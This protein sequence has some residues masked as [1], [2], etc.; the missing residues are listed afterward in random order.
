M[1]GVGLQA[2]VADEVLAR[3]GALR[4]TDG[5]LLW[6]LQVVARL[7]RCGALVHGEGGFVWAGGTWPADFA[8]PAHMQAAIQEQ[9]ENAAQ[10]HAVLACAACGCNGLQFPVSVLAA[11]LG[12]TCLELLIVLDEI[13]RSLGM[14]HDVR[15]RDDLYAFHSSFLLEVIRGKLGI[16]GP[17]RAPGKCSPDCSRVPRVP[18]HRPG[19]GPRGFPRQSL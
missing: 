8:I 5:G 4:E 18:G 15:D 6:P 13:E 2:A 12:R 11:A 14:V 3:T 19:K 16:G 10:Y 7:A 9:W 1:G 17:E